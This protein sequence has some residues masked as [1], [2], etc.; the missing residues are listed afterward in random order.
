[1]ARTFVASNPRALIQRIDRKI[2]VVRRELRRREKYD[3]YCA[4]SCQ[5]AWDRHPELS[6]RHR[7][8]FWLRGEFQIHRNRQE[9]EQAVRAARAFVAHRPRKGKPCKTC[10]G[11]GL[12]AA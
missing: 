4:A 6:R 9:R 7:L 5:A 3:A 1:M 2:D 8:L 10:K 11:S 12:A